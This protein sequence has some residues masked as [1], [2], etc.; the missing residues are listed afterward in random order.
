[1]FHQRN[2][3]ISILTS[4]SVFFRLSS[5]T[6]QCTSIERCLGTSTSEECFPY[7]SGT[8]Q[9]E[10]PSLFPAENSRD[11]P[12]ALAKFHKRLLCWADISLLLGHSAEFHLYTAHR[13]NPACRIGHL[14]GSKGLVSHQLR[15]YWQGREQRKGSKLDTPELE[16]Y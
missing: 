8:H 13:T 16:P 5:I 2:Q 12:Q 7:Q 6:T 4:H 1:M 10:G 11:M 15:G 9:G 14:A 3:L